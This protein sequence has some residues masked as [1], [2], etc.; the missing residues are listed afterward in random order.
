ML[1]R[2]AGRLALVLETSAP[3][4]GAGAVGFTV[5]SGSPLVTKVYHIPSGCATSHMRKGGLL[6]ECWAYTCQP[7]AN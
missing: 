1:L 4:K 7:S 3:P 5:L 2:S 6:G